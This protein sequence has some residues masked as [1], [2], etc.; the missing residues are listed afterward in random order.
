[1]VN[2]TTDE[3]TRKMLEAMAQKAETTAE[4]AF[5][6]YTLGLQVE[7]AAL[8]LSALIVSAV[9]YVA[10][11]KTF[12]HVEEKETDSLGHPDTGDAIFLSVAV[13]AIS[14]GVAMLGAAVISDALVQL[15]VPEYALMQEVIQNTL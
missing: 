3:A 13:A 9:A 4:Q 15:A 6:L 14:G 1:M 8:L 12:N 2:V 11:K 5:E 7:A 10:G